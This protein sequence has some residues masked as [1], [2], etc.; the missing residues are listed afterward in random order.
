MSYQFRLLQK[1]EREQLLVWLI[2]SGQ[3]KDSGVYSVV[4][5]NKF[6]R[7]THNQTYSGHQDPR[8]EEIIDKNIVLQTK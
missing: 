5:E 3:L 7:I 2:I 8:I 4:V 6:Y 1:Q